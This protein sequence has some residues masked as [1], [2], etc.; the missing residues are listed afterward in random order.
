MTDDKQSVEI[1]K[2]EE[3][4]RALHKLTLQ[5]LL[6][7]DQA[8]ISIDALMKQLAL[9]S[10]QVHGSGAI[11]QGDGAK[12]VGAGGLLVEGGIK[13]DD[14]LVDHTNRPAG[15]HSTDAPLPD[16]K[17]NKKKTK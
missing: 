17:K 12:A 1:Q 6:S 4:I 16:I 5:N 3:T 2:I 15:D 9:Y 13:G 14:I 8:R 7:E 10:A 11:A